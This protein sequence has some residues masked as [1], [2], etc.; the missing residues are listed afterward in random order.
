MPRLGGFAIEKDSLNLESTDNWKGG[1]IMAPFDKEVCRC[2]VSKQK[3]SIYFYRCIFL[4]V[5]VL[6]GTVSK[7]KAM[8]ANPG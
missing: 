8:E 7:T 1:T 4:W 5:L 3:K 6:V 2:N